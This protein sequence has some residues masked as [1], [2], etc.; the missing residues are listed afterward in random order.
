MTIG[1]RRSR[2]RRGKEKMSLVKYAER[3]NTDSVKWDGLEEKFGADDLL[4]LWVAD[5]DFEA[6]ECVKESLRAYVEAGVFAYYRAPE[7]F[8]ESFIEWESQYFGY[9]IQRE[10]IRYAPGVVPAVHTLVQAFTEEGEGVIVLEPVYYPFFEAIENNGRILVKSPLINTEGVYTIDFADFERRL[11]EHNVKLFILCSPHNP[12][13]R[14]WTKEELQRLHEICTRH[15]VR[16]LADEIHQDI[17]TKAHTQLSLGA[18]VDDANVITVTAATKTFNLASVQN[19]FVIIPSEEDAAVYD[20]CA[21]ESRVIRGG[22]FGY[23]AVE[24]A[25]RGG[26]PW[27]EEALD[28]IEG[29]YR[30]L[31]TILEESEHEITVSPLEGTYLAW[32]DLSKALKGRNCVE[33]IQNQAKLAVDFGDWFGGDAYGGFVRINLATKEENIREAAERIVAV[34]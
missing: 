23:I 2:I 13:G 3:K 14:V 29:N 20:Q 6:P 5:M 9:K 16:I 4:A 19:A 18:L 8:E 1:V 17:T 28:I 11:V 27:L 25:L 12:V 10:W 7:T 31:Q 30:V 33:V 34:L 24:S 22:S 32:V 26:R 21:L 15:H